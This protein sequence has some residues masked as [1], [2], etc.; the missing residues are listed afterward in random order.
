VP[1]RWQD[2]GTLPP[3]LPKAP[4]PVRIKKKHV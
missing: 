4:Q 3:S 2:P 1:V